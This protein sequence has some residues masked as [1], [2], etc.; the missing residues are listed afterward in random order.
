MAPKKKPETAE[1]EEIPGAPGATF[2]LEDADGPAVAATAEVLAPPAASPAASEPPPKP[3]AATH[4]D[5]LVART[6]AVTMGDGVRPRSADRLRI[7]DARG[8]RVT[9]TRGT[10]RDVRLLPP[11]AR[12]LA[13]EGWGVAVKE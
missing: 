2:E 5:D 12:Q 9:F 4:A 11:V 13:G 1:S 7:E 10:T 6:Y 3:R 8:N